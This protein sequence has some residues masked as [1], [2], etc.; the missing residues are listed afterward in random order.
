L[1]NLKGAELQ[2]ANLQG[3]QLYDVYLQGANLQAVNLK[4]AYLSRVKI[5]GANLH[6]AI[7]QDTIFELHTDLKGADLRET[8]GLVIGQLEDTEGDNRTQ[9][10]QGFNRPESWDEGSEEPAET[11]EPPG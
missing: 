6:G 11:D 2:G 7:L 10:P 9:L 1:T 3:A 4:G 8:Q 5:Q